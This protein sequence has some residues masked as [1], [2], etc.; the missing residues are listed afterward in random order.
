MLSGFS[1]LKT[2]SLRIVTLHA[3]E[4]RLDAF[5]PG[6]PLVWE[7][8][9]HLFLGSGSSGADGGLSFHN[10]IV[11]LGRCK[12]LISF[13]FTPNTTDIE[14]D[15]VSGSLL[16]P[17][18]EIFI[19]LDPY[20]STPRSVK[21]LVDC[22]S[23]PELRQFSVPTSIST[24]PDSFLL[25]P[26][27]QRSPLVED[28]TIQLSSLT[29]QSLPETFRSFPSLLT[30]IVFDIYDRPPWGDNVDRDPAFDYA[31]ATQLLAL[32]TPNLEIT[33]CPALQELILRKCS[34]L[35]KST[36]DAFIQGRMEHTQGFQRLEI[37]FQYP[38]DKELMSDDE[39]QL[40]LSRGLDISLANNNHWGR[41]VHS[42]P[43]PWT[44]LPLENQW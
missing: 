23:M 22:L 18:L 40:Y 4:D 38:V 11:V 2:P 26:L 16:L 28:L 41:G 3:G 44:G 21:R 15:F 39:I 37:V 35:G 12:Q 24:G 36:L 30:L 43:S 5:I 29:K 25:V 1:L 34:A 6:L 20:F 31:D 33:L 42:P 10:V 7:Q 19:A 9:T 8:L 27:G 14:A 13:H 17:F 32:L